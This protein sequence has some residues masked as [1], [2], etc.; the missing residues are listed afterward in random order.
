MNLRR[1]VS[2]LLLACLLSK[3]AAALGAGEDFPEIALDAVPPAAQPG[4]AEAPADD[5]GPWGSWRG[6]VGLRLHHAQHEQLR[7]YAFKRSEPGITSARMSLRLEG[8]VPLGTAAQLHAGGRLSR[9]FAQLDG[10]PYSEALLEQTYV[11][12]RNLGPW[13]LRFGR[14]LVALGLSDYFQLLDVVNPRDERILGLADLRESR[15]PVLATRLGYEHQRSGVEL[16]VKHEF[17]SHRYGQAQS[18]FDPFI[19]LGGLEQVA[20]WTKPALGSRPDA[21]LRWYSSSA[22]GDVHAIAGRVHDPMPA[23]LGVENGRFV[24]GHERATV[25][26]IGGNF[27]RGDWVVKSELARRSATRQMRSD[28]ALQ[29]EQPSPTLSE[30]RPQTDWMLGARYTGVVGFTA[31]TELLT[32][33]INHHDGTL[34]DAR[35]RH[36]AVLNLE[37]SAM[38]DKL[39]L[40]LLLGRW[41]G[42][43]RVVRATASYDLD[44]R[45]Q[46]N[47]GLMQYGGGSETSPLF[48]YRRNDRVIVGVTY[49]L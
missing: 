12:A 8:D 16:I 36:V 44:D 25:L 24:L 35:V 23:L 38:H 26:G 2:R 15:L 14:Q 28:L 37:W 1:V 7:S 49:S 4:G 27:V 43:G 30:V 39:R 34:A 20:R 32:Q 41:W 22:W 10:Q 18:D 5:A 6:D 3:S 13:R 19:V 33:V 40:G 17:R 21:V 31:D 42:G 45:W 29:L 48:P 47:A 46:L 11:E 9:E